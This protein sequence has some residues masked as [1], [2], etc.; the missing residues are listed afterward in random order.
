MQQELPTGFSSS[1]FSQDHFRLQHRHTHNRLTELLWMLG[2]PTHLKGYRFLREAVEQAL[3]TQSTAP[4]LSTQLY[5]LVA[6]IH[7]TT[8]SSVERSIRTAIDTAWKRGSLSA[9]SSLFCRQV[10]PDY[11][12]PTNGEIIALLAE[13]LRMEME[14]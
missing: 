6:N 2:I 5:P 1:I 11:A 13:K 14:L 4:S 3:L 12:K 10:S 7:H 8:V 9:A